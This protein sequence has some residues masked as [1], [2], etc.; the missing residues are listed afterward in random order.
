MENHQT[1]ETKIQLVRILFPWYVLHPLEKIERKLAGSTQRSNR[2]FYP[3]NSN[4]N[5]HDSIL[6]VGSALY[7]IYIKGFRKAHSKDFRKRQSVSS[8]T[9]SFYVTNYVR[10]SGKARC[11]HNP[12]E[13][14]LS[15]CLE[16]IQ[17]IFPCPFGT[18]SA[19]AATCSECQARLY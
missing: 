18:T 8:R 12:I 7:S 5:C 6:F 10:G 17:R 19:G 3:F 4:F 9:L 2:A 13:P 15:G 1:F 11:N 14:N 16:T